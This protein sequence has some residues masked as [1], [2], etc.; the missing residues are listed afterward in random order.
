MSPE[1]VPFSARNRAVSTPTAPPPMITTRG[2][3]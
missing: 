2:P 1:S 3:V